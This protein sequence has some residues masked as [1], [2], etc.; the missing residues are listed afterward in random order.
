MKAKN[1][2]NMK[3]CCQLTYVTTTAKVKHLIKEDGLL[4]ELQPFL[5]TI[6]SIFV[7]DNVRAKFVAPQKDAVI[8]P[9]T[10]PWG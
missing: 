6:V 8:K 10:S 5:K 3:M 2:Q 1:N 4:L 7:F 9:L